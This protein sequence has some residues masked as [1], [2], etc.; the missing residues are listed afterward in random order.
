MGKL[1]RPELHL[2]DSESLQALGVVYNLSCKIH[3]LLLNNKN[4]S[5]YLF[6][7]E[8]M[9]NFY[10]KFGKRMLVFRQK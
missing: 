5:V 8:Q 4:F 2:K 10:S 1:F 6:A 3:L 7:Q 9:I